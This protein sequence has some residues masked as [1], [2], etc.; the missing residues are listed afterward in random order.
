LAEHSP[1]D[2]TTL[3]G[4]RVDIHSFTFDASGRCIYGCPYPVDS[5]TGTGVIAGYAVK[6]ISPHWMVKFHSG[7]T[8]DADDY[9]DVN[10]LCTAFGISLPSEFEPFRNAETI[11]EKA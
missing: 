3:D 2:E 8:L 10:A 5:L 1:N 9:R 11:A 6:C 4:H 7:Y